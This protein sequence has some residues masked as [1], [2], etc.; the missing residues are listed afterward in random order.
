MHLHQPPPDQLGLARL[1][2]PD[3]HVRLA[4]RQVEDPL[5]E[6]QVDLQVR[7][8]L[9]QPVQPRRQPE[10]AEAGGRGDP[11][12]AVDLVLAVADARRRRLQPLGHRPRRL[13]Q[14]LPLLG[15]EQPARV[16]AEERGVEALLQRADLPA[17]RRLAEVQRVAGMGQAARVGHGMEDS[18]LV[19]VHG[20]PHRPVVGA[21]YVVRSG[22]AITT[23]SARKPLRSGEFRGLPAERDIFCRFA[24]SREIGLVRRPFRLIFQARATVLDPGSGMAC[25]TSRSPTASTSPRRR[26]S[27][28]ASRRWSASC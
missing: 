22:G 4:H 23:Y 21:A 2:Q 14:Q 11:Q 13:E 25:T 9:E 6:H 18:Q 5:L 24:R 26:C 28:A 8:A 12:L 17:D 27:S 1:L 7:I 3:R 16:P 19:P 15:Q 10:R 20:I